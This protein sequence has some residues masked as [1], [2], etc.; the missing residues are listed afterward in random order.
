[1]SLKYL[2]LTGLSR[3][4]TNLKNWVVSRI[5]TK[6][7]EITNDSGFIT[8]SSLPT[9][10]NATLT[11]QKNGTNI[12]TFT[13]NASSNKTANITVP[14]KTSE[15]TNDSGYLTSHQSLSNYSTLT[16]TIK[17][18][19]ISGKTIT[20][21]KGDN[22]TGTLTTQ[23]TNTDTLVNQN[24]STVN[25]T[26]P[27][28]IAHTANA[29]ENLGA[30]AAYFGKDVKINPSTG[31]L[32]AT[33]LYSNGTEVL[34]SH[35]SLSNYST[36][37]NTVKSLSISGK[38][39][40]V[41][42]G[43]GSA[44]TLTTQDTVYT[45][46]TSAGNKHI[47]SGGSSG[48]FLGWDS[49]G[50]AKWVNNP[51][52]NTDT[53]V[54]QNV[55]TANENHPILLTVTKD[56]AANQ[57]AKTSIFASGVTVNPSTNTVTATTFSGA[58]SGNASSATKFSANKAVTLTGDVTGTASSKAG[59]SVATTLADSGVTAGTYGPTADV[60]GN[61]NA[62]ISVPEITVDAKGR[63]T[64]VTNRTLTC[65]NNTYS[66]YNKTLTIQKN[67][68][69]VA[70]FTSNSN[71][72][73]TA[74]I[75]VPTKTSELTNDSGYLTSHQSLSD[76]V[77]LNTAQNISANKFFYG[78]AWRIGSNYPSFI[79]KNNAHTVGE[80]APS[81]MWGYG[82]FLIQDKNA[83][84]VCLLSCRYDQN[85]TQYFRIECRNKF[86]NGAPAVDGT[87]VSSVL[88]VGTIADGTRYIYWNSF[89]NNGLV[90]RI[91]SAWNIGDA[92]HA[93]NIVYATNYKIKGPNTQIGVTTSNSTVDFIDIVDANNTQ[94]GYIGRWQHN[95]GYSCITLTCYDKYDGAGN[96][97]TSGT[98][99]NGTLEIGTTNTGVPYLNYNTYFMQN[100]TPLTNDNN[101]L[102][103]ASHHWRNLF[104]GEIHCYH[105]NAI[106]MKNGSYTFLLR[107]DGSYLWFL[108]SAA[109]GNE[110]TW[111]D[112][113][114]LYINCANGA[115]S[116]TSTWNFNKSFGDSDPSILIQSGT[117]Y[118]NGTWN[119]PLAAL[120]PNMKAGA[121]LFMPIGRNFA[122]GNCAGWH[123]CYAGNNSND[124]Y[125]SVEFYAVGSHFA[126][127]R[128]GRVFL[129]TTPATSD[130]STRVATTAYVKN[131]GYLSGTVPIA[132]GGTGS[133]T[134]LGAVQ[135]LTNEHVG[136]STQYF[137]TITQNWGKAGYCSVDDAKT[138]LGI[139]TTSK[140]LTLIG[141]RETAGTWTLTC[142][143]L[144]PIYFKIIASKTSSSAEFVCGIT[145]SSTCRFVMQANNYDTPQIIYS[146]VST[147]SSGVALWGIGIPTSTSITVEVWARNTQYQ[148]V[149]NVKAYQ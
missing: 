132:N 123:W 69:N 76:Y 84:S 36:L 93:W 103:D 136:T 6:T 148:K 138:V 109:N 146:V 149:F 139:G 122:A 44:Y 105:Q 37:A 82:E 71:T 77:T 17:S 134:R 62:T 51:N 83:Y 2:N 65:K 57:G 25:N 101:D 41:T 147:S 130:N 114:P 8:S 91:T 52:T 66:V 133:T 102:G 24:V 112:L 42:P 127:Y 67:G 99:A 46:P 13:A 144:A 18:L 32:Y 31:A 26:F 89:I 121:N 21:T 33:K 39:I 125:V 11:I 107:N 113:R 111:N 142:T 137:L 19:S 106:M 90:P 72:D 74:N 4:I 140:K 15:L 10:N 87:A 27:V 104:I 141:E 110:G 115:C 5:P 47:P 118:A 28:L 126:V 96:R 38:T 23:D 79:C 3:V 20:Y 98:V 108:I 131:Q 16:N 7:S 9:V 22:T 64:S 29:T 86:T 81:S 59:W 12:Q 143:T 117:E 75:T 54:T 135:N 34:T 73:V 30:K 129:S 63:V 95:N 58:L 70:T 49:D 43:S 145:S 53:L 100:I 85:A 14:T 40:T 80:A 35:Q 120:A 78:G 119:Y 97:S 94:L 128:D 124:N 88:D 50:T 48:Q 61:N 92:S 55:S 68:T 56:A 116:T 1:M 45:H 60:T